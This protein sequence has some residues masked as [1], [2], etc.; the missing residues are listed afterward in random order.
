MS[1][2]VH[3]ILA[4]TLGRSQVRHPR[5][6]VEAV[7]EDGWSESVQRDSLGRYTSGSD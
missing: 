3:E 1:E 7:Y 4:N 2:N 6:P 5:G